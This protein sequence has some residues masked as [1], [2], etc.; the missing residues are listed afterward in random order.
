MWIAIQHKQ[1][2]TAAKMEN[3]ILEF[4]PKN[5]TSNIYS[6]CFTLVRFGLTSPQPLCQVMNIT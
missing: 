6:I 4:I 1:V 2:D 5:V 3:G